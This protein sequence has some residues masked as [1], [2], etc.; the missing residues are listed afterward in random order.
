MQSETRT[1]RSTGRV[2][3]GR[4]LVAASPGEPVV[5]CRGLTKRYGELV[6]VDGVTFSLRAGTVTGDLGPNGAGKTTTLRLLLGMAEPTAGG[7][8]AR[9]HAERARGRR[10]RPLE[11]RRAT[12]GFPGRLQSRHALRR[13]RRRDRDHGRDPLRHTLVGLCACTFLVETTSESFVPGAAR[14]LP[15]GAGTA[16]AGNSDALPGLRR[17]APARP[18]RR[19]GRRRRLARDPPPRHRMSARAR[20]VDSAGAGWSSP[21]RR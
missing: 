14:F 6:A 16:L 1:E 20:A 8:R 17:S 10:R 19:R 12:A 7:A 21:E 5:I 2:P 18:L 9:D 13:P 11:R 15:G 4:E 3:S